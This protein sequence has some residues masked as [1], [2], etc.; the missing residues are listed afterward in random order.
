MSSTGRASKREAKDFYP[1]PPWLTEAL[2]EELEELLIPPE[3][4]L[5]P[6]A[7]DGAITKVLEETWPLADIHQLD[8]R[9]EPSVDFLTEPPKPEFDL[10]ITN[11]PYS[12]ALEFVKRAMEWRRNFNSTVVMLLR[13]NWLGS[14]VRA[15]WLRKN[16]PEVWVTPRRPCFIKGTADSC[17]YA[18]FLW[19]PQIPWGTRWLSTEKG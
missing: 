11:P 10:I 1:T 16:P 7:G 14:Q 8:I 6:A 18:W 17:E 2:C 12:H 9:H 13:L 4:I 15:S 5:E 3:S 19:G